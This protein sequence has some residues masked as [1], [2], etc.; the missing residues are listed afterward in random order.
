MTQRTA[1]G[2]VRTMEVLGLFALCLM[3]SPV[4]RWWGAAGAFTLLVGA[5]WFSRWAAA[6]I[7]AGSP[8]HPWANGRV[9][10]VAAI[11]ALA[12]TAT[13][14]VVPTRRVVWF[15][16]RAR[17]A[18]RELATLMQAIEHSEPK[19]PDAE[20]R[21]ATMNAML[22]AWDSGSPEPDGPLW[23]LRYQPVWRE[24]PGG[25]MSLGGGNWF[26]GEGIAWPTVFAE[27]GLILFLGG[28]VLA[29]VVRRERRKTVPSL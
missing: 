15:D 5:N 16:R 8:P 25:R 26:E 1:R 22:W 7:A 19:S 13:L 24:R 3:V 17:H 4:W 28:A 12:I 2:I 20:R 18:D 10:L 21:L 23:P 14:I 9:A 27:Q 29:F 11:V 6:H